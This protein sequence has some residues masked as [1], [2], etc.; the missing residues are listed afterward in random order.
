MFLYLFSGA[1]GN[2]PRIFQQVGVDDLF[3]LPLVLLHPPDQRLPRHE[4]DQRHTQ[5]HVCKVQ[6]NDEKLK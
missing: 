5:R 4:G 6:L 3:P 1:K 2:I